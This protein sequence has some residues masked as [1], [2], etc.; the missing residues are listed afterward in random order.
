MFA[1]P[2]YEIA[3]DEPYG[4]VAVKGDSRSLAGHGLVTFLVGRHG[5]DTM[6]AL[7]SRAAA[8]TSNM[9]RRSWQRADA[10]I[11]GGAA[12]PPRA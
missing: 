5:G 4:G 12:T 6:T 9:S 2:N 8:A 3:L 11:C 10:T 1:V 7:L